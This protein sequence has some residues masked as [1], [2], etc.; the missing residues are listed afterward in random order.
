MLR[1][2]TILTHLRDLKQAIEDRRFK[3]FSFHSLDIFRFDRH[4][5]YPLVHLSDKVDVKVKPVEL[6]EG[7]RNFVVDLRDYYQ[8][9]P[10]Q[11][12]DTELYLLRNMTRGKGIG[13]FEAGNFYPD[14][15]LWLLYPDTQYVTF[16]D[17]KGIRNLEGETDPKIDFYRTIKEIERDLGD[18]GVVLN[19][20]IIANTPYRNLKA[21]KLSKAEIEAR[22]VLLQEDDRSTYIE[23]LFLGLRVERDS[24]SVKAV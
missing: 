4:L 17:P 5:Y 14:F 7:E 22:N 13:F 9:N 2:T 16:I 21:W 19:S 6:N 10:T 15:I 12:E 1:Q 24:R 18:P 20:F 11:F 8:R 3:D 23:K